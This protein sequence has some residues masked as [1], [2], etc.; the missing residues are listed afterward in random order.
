MFHVQSYFDVL[1]S[2]TV[3]ISLA[4]TI[5]HVPLLNCQVNRDNTI[6]PVVEGEF[7]THQGIVSPTGNVMAIKCLRLLSR[8][9]EEGV[10]VMFSLVATVLLGAHV[11]TACSLWDLHLVT[12]RA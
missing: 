1:A 10:G 3:P 4:R 11:H 12:T 7:V 6:P 2:R 5:R 9:L 8:H